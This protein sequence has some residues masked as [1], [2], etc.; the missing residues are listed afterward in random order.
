MYA[1]IRNMSVGRYKKFGPVMALQV[2]Y[3]A[4]ALLCLI[5][6]FGKWQAGAYCTLVVTVVYLLQIILAQKVR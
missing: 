1:L 3:V 4:N 6:F 2:A 5:E